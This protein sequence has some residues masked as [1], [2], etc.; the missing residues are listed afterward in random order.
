LVRRSG[1]VD[2]LRPSR[3]L[4]SYALW[5]SLGAQTR[6][7]LRSH[8]KA[9]QLCRVA[10]LGKELKRPTFLAEVDEQHVIPGNGYSGL[11]R[12]Q[13][14][15]ARGA[16]PIRESLMTGRLAGRLTC[17]TGSGP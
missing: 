3:E 4:S 10:A 17:E 5:D 7:E 13:H 14:Y 15:N 2:S 1:R 9:N 6:R 8:L 16:K 11:S 12:T